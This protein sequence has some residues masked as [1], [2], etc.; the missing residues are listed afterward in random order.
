[1]AFWLF[2]KKDSAVAEFDSAVSEQPEW[3]NPRWVQALYSTL[4][5]DT[6]REIQT[7]S[8]RRLNLRRAQL[9]TRP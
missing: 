3:K 2:A 5:A 4:V 9:A 1:V 7:E 6:I 8:N